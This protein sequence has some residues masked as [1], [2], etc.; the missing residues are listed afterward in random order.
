MKRHLNHALCLISKQ[1]FNI[2]SKLITKKNVKI[3]LYTDSRGTEISRMKQKNPYFSYLNH[4]SDYNVEYHFCPHKYTSI[5]DFLE[6]IESK[7][8]DYDL[9]ILHCGIVDFAPRPLSSYNEMLASKKKYI[10][11][12]GWGNYFYNRTDFHCDYEGEK[13][14]Q[15]FSCDFLKNEIAPFFSKGSNCIYVGVN[16][17][18]ENWNGSYWRKRPD[19]INIQLEQDVYFSTLFQYKVSLRDWT[20]IEIRKFTTDNVH[21][22]KA[23]LDFI[24][25]NL[26]IE[27]SKVIKNVL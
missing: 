19:C 10:E 23:G 2:H 6:L 3:L 26:A 14:L 22:S 17:V 12:K 13:T 11:Q 5:L 16:R 25:C 21:Y 7:S 27:I 15:F 9:I 8:C 20:D 4:L 24:G 18:L 1:I